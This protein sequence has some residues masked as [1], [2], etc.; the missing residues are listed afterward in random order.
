MAW[1]YPADLVQNQPATLWVQTLEQS[2]PNHSQDEGSREQKWREDGE[3]RGGGKKEQEEE[4]KPEEELKKEEKREEEELCPRKT[5]VSK[6]LMHTLWE[7]FKLN[8]CPRAQ[9]CLSLAFEFNI[10]DTQV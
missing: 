3:R 8:Q 1:F 2:N 5:A 7:K 6:P 9:D 4:N 10:T